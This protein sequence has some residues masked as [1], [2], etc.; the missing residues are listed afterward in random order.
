[1][2][3]SSQKRILYVVRRQI[4]WERESRFS[5]KRLTPGTLVVVA[6]N[7]SKICPPVYNNYAASSRKECFYQLSF[8]SPLDFWSQLHN[9]KLPSLLAN[10]EKCAKKWLELS[11]QR[12][13]TKAFVS[14]SISYNQQRSKTMIIRRAFQCEYFQEL[15]AA[16]RKN[17]ASRE[18]RSSNATSGRKQL[19]YY[20][21]LYTL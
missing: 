1:M 21:Y 3:R 8:C 5:Q 13:S 16:I 18:K 10:L 17:N 15:V 12:V 14:V 6:S 7:F 9:H 11:V 2:A 19:R 20:S 4:M